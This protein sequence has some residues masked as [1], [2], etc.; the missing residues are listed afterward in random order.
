MVPGLFY[1]LQAKALLWNDLRDDGLTGSESVAE[2]KARLKT[3]IFNKYF[4]PSTLLPL[5]QFC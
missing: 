4:Q 1:I 3:H 2:F 5:F